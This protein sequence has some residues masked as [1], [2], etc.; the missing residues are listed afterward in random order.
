MRFSSGSAAPRLPAQGQTVEHRARVQ[1]ADRTVAAVVGA[2]E[3]AR[4][5][6]PPRRRRGRLLRPS[7]SPSPQK[8]V[9]STLRPASPLHPPRLLVLNSCQRASSSLIRA[10]IAHLSTISALLPRRAP[11]SAPPCSASPVQGQ[12]IECRAR[13]GRLDDATAAVVGAPNMAPCGHLPA[14]LLPTALPAVA[15]VPCWH[16]LRRASVASHGS[17]EHHGGRRGAA[18][19][20]GVTAWKAVLVNRFGSDGMVASAWWE[21]AAQAG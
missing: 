12:N 13:V 6:A 19:K 10:D 7:P 1:T 18:V 21:M 2:H 4:A 15:L 9:A 3:V 14:G 8:Q 17:V 16:Q 11:P 20:D 5:L